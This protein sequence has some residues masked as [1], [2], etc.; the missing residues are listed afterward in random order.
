[1]PHSLQVK[2]P[3]VILFFVANPKK[4]TPKIRHGIITVRVPHP[5][6]AVTTIAATILNS[7][8]SPAFG[9]TADAPIYLHVLN[10]ERCASFS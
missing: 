6:I 3:Y 1:V 7:G 9:N 4:G 8:A 2:E 5:A 10:L